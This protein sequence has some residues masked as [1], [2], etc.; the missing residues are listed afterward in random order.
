MWFLKQ[1][2]LNKARKT[3][4]S[5]IISGNNGADPGPLQTDTFQ[6][7]SM[8]KYPNFTKEVQ[9][10][11]EKYRLVLYTSGSWLAATILKYD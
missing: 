4:F 7:K 9:Q 2:T 10:T 8:D 11:R 1:N 3:Q 5:H 6:L